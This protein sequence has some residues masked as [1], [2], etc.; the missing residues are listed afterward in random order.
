MTKRSVV[1]VAVLRIF[2]G[3]SLGACTVP[4]P[5]FRGDACV[6]ETD[7]EFC[8]RIGASCD[9]PTGNDN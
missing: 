8:A 3:A 1:F 2:V 9:Q 4:N 7:A 6:A 5:N